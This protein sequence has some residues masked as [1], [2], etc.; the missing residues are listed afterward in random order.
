VLVFQRSA[1]CIA[2]AGHI[3]HDV[4]AITAV[5]IRVAVLIHLHGVCYDGTTENHTGCLA[6]LADSGQRTL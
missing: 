3:G 5:I 2:D 4:R 1:G 6:C